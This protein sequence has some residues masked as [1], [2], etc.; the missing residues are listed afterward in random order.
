MQPDTDRRKA[1]TLKA[2][3]VGF[4]VS[5]AYLTAWQVLVEGVTCE[6]TGVFACA[7]PGLLMYLIGVPLAYVAWSLGLTWAGQALPWLAPLVVMGALVIVVPL[8]GSMELS[9]AWWLIV[10]A[11]MSAGWARWTLTWSQGA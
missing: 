5:G 9:Q 8:T 3:L 4:L 2:G 10:V 11:V 6:S 7:G 1:T